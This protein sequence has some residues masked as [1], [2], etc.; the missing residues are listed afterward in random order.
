MLLDD[1]YPQD[2]RVSKEADAL[3]SAGHEVVLLCYRGENEPRREAVDGI[4][5]I[6][7]PL[8]HAH[9]SVGN[10]PEGIRYLLMQVHQPWLSAI[11]KV[12]S[13]EGID[14]I[15][16]HD[17]P[18]VKTALAAGRRHGL[19]VVADLHENW[20][21]AIRQYRTVGRLW[22]LLK[23]PQL[24][25]GRLATPV[26]R[27]KRL[28]RHCVSRA[29]HVITV[30][31]EARSHYVNDCGAD[32]EDVTVV[33]NTVRL[34]DFDPDTD[35]VGYT[36]DFV[37]GYVGSLGGEHRGLK[38]VI[39]AMPEI[40]AA[41]PDARLLIVGSGPAYESE[42]RKRARE[43]GIADR[44]TFTG[45]VDFED[46]PAHIAASDVCLVPH[47]STPHTETTVPHKLFQY[48]ALGKPVI[49][50]D[51]GP[52]ARIVTETNAGLVI[53]PGDP[54]AVSVAAKRLYA[55]PGEA[56]A[57][58]VNGQRAVETTYN[59]ENEVDRLLGVYDRFDTGH[60]SRQDGSDHPGVRR[61]DHSS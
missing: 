20:P 13:A 61:H 58:G 49:V 1:T 12:V 51:V 50:A 27:L 25:A 54:D 32:P 36:G 14:A 38:S 37:L 23:R 60:R 46:V 35:P 30:A 33:S 18:L 47:R 57:F 7:R 48:M 40:A 28:E 45:W 6:R 22:Q 34:A 39:D 29:D 42:L 44:T 4:T 52:L 19:P 24:L 55:N 43:N 17:L 15:H 21:E 10:L 5:V 3:R 41:I 26:S 2:I 56:A 53:P 8:Q 59:W 9:E 31:E 16:P 11:E